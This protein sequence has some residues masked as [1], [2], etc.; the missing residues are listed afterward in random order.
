MAGFKGIKVYYANAKSALSKS[1]LPDLDYALNPYIGCSHGCLYCY[2]RLYTRDSRVSSNWG[3]VVVVKINI[4]KALL[5]EVKRLRP[6]VVGVGTITDA[7][8]PLEAVYKLTRGCIG[9][10]LSHGFRVS[11][12]TKN[13]LVVRDLDLFGKYRDFVDVGFTITTTND[14]VAKLI[15]PRSPPPS[16]RI[17][18][19]E[20]LSSAGVKT[21]VFYGPVIPGVNDGERD[22]REIV[23]IAYK[24]SSTLYYDPLHVKPFMENPVHPLHRYAV[25]KTRDWWSRVKALLLK[26]C[27]EYGLTCKPGFTGDYQG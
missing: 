3:S 24:T 8:Q 10:L 14:P 13:T 5:R 7:Y 20:N 18:A 1:G 25:K 6:G 11:I 23:E 9:V 21:W 19:L 17:R 12:Q 4:L 16:A 2:A 26:Y 27:R 15:E 22:V